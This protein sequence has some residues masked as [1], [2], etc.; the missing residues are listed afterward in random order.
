M[1]ADRPCLHTHMPLVMDQELDDLF[2]DHGDVPSIQI[3]QPL[4]NDLL[5]HLDD[6]RSTGCCQYV[7]PKICCGWV[8]IMEQADR[9]VQGGLH[10]LHYRQWL[11]RQHSISLLQPGEW[12]VGAKRAAISRW[13][14][15][16]TWGHFAGSSILESAGK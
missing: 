13:S 3:P 12:Q 4:P 7:D 8:L 1:N 15:V 5:Q 10:C 14:F 2:G 16:F 6:L 9:L 11:R